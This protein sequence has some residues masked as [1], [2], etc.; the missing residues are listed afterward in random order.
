VNTAPE[1]RDKKWFDGCEYR[2]AI[3]ECKLT[4]FEPQVLICHIGKTHSMSLVEYQGHFRELETKVSW[5]ACPAPDC[6]AKLKH[7][8]STL[9]KHAYD[10]HGL[11]LDEFESKFILLSSS[12]D[13]ANGQRDQAKDLVDETNFENWSR[14]RCLYVCSICLTETRDSSE[15]W[16]QRYKTFFIN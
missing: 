14:G 2:C 4:F 11:E 10:I 3:A 7:Q 1:P 9:S 16:C 13:S 12:A 5:F 8:K 6:L 15:F